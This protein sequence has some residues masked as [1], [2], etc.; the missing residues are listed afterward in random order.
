VAD[1]EGRADVHAIPD[2]HTMAY[3]DTDTGTYCYCG[4]YA[5][6][7]RDPVNGDASADGYGDTNAHTDCDTADGNTGTDCYG[8]TDPNANRRSDTDTNADS[9]THTCL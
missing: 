8:S 4:T 7:D 1:T 5:D 9:N 3:V 6:S 2:L